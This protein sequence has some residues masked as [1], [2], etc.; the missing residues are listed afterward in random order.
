MNHTPGDALLIAYDRRDFLAEK[1]QA[2]ELW[3]T[4]IENA[5]AGPGEAADGSSTGSAEKACN[6][7]KAHTGAK[8]S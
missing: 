2:L 6:G 8:T 3:A 1:A 5:T 4:A 7:A